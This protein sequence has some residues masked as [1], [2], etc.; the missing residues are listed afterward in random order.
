MSRF[1]RDVF[2]LQTSM[3]GST[4]VD[5]EIN[6]SEIKKKTRII[7]IILIITIETGSETLLL[8]FEL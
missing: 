7:S 8:S 4:A 6:A 3:S 5:Y 2:H 1:S